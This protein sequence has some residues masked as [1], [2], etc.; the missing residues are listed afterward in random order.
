[1]FQ[2]GLHV[3]AL[4]DRNKSGNVRNIVALLYNHCCSGTHYECSFVAL[5]IQD[6][7]RVRYIVICGQPRS[8]LFCHIFS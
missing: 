4:M 6:A 1:M 2:H 7:M 5:G 8:A 3:S